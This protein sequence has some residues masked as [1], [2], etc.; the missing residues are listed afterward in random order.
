MPLPPPMMRVATAGKFA[1][2]QD[3]GSS[4][5]TP[6]L[7]LTSLGPDVAPDWAPG[8]GG[9]ITVTAVIFVD[10]NAPLAGQVGSL[11]HPFRTVQQGITAAAALVADSAIVR[12]AP[13]TYT[14]VLSVPATTLS[15]LCLEGWG[16]QNG[17]IATALP[18]VDGNITV[19]PKGGGGAPL[20]VSLSA[21]EYLGTIRTVDPATQDL[22]VYLFNVAFTGSIE[23]NNLFVRPN[24][25]SVPNPSTFEGTTSLHLDTDGY[26]WGEILRSG[27][28]LIPGLAP[29]YVRTFYEEG[30]DYGDESL[31]V[32]GLAIGASQ[33]VTL[34]IGTAR[35]GEVAAVTKLGAVPATDFQLVFSHTGAGNATFILTNL[36]RASTNFNDDVRVVVWHMGMATTPPPP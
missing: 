33:P 3:Y 32:Q 8:G 2:A 12:I 10:S 1:V 15:V 23:A 14:E 31:D 20:F 16:H 5:A 36:S 28:L 35:P 22:N 25:L 29:E 30:C 24:H 19:A 7:V 27:T 21:L 11:D 9:S 17:N 26:S 18:T 13:G 6:G 4:V 34:A